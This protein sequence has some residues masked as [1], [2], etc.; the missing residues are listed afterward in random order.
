MKM[1][2]EELKEQKK[3]DLPLQT[4]TM[5]VW[6]HPVVVSWLII[7][8]TV[9][10]PWLNCKWVPYRYFVISKAD[11]EVFGGTSNTYVV[12]HIY[13]CCNTCTIMYF[14]IFWIFF[15]KECWTFSNE[16]KGKAFGFF[17]WKMSFAYFHDF[18]AGL[19]TLDYS[20]RIEIWNK[21]VKIVS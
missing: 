18:W 12:I 17:P 19:P 4:N 14:E 6:Y 5:A 9:M 2:E 21:W 13:I 20:N 3:L 8:I 11:K 15:P 10:A 1:K 7:K 16:K